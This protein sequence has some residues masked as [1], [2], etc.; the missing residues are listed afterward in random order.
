MS[1][2]RSSTFP[3]WYQK[4]QVALAAMHFRFLEKRRPEDYAVRVSE[5]M[6]WPVPPELLISAP[7]LVWE[8]CED[9]AQNGGEKQVLELLQGLRVDRGRAVLM[10]RPEEH[11]K[12]SGSS[13]PWEI[14]PWY[15]TAYRVE[16][17]DE[18]FV[19]QVGSLHSQREFPQLQLFCR[20]KART[21]YL[22][23]TCQGPTSSFQLTWT[24]IS[25]RSPRLAFIRL[26]GS[27]TL[28]FFFLFSHSSVLSLF[29]KVL[30]RRYGI[31]KTTF[32]G[33]QKHMLEYA[34]PRTLR[35]VLFKNPHS[36]ALIQTS[37]QRFPS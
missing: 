33:S 2:L 36:Q 9:D 15:G 18:D 7:Q 20:L 32:F 12:I 19:R 8:W 28:F 11:N 6:V 27:A 25:E 26:T 22:N 34:Y 30:I 24:W 3:A 14:E 4:E 35:S 23:C 21:I 31:R 5:Q 37:G 17:F 1:L 29:A 10:A 13:N 16:R